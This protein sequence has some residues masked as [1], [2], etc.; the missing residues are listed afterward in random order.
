MPE[1]GRSAPMVLL[2]TL[3]SQG[4]ARNRGTRPLKTMVPE[5]AT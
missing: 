1:N 2:K 5:L 3:Q 4:F